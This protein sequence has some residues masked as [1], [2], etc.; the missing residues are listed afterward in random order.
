MFFLSVI[1][2]EW[3]NLSSTYFSYL[4]WIMVW[5]FALLLKSSLINKPTLTAWLLHTI[6]ALWDQSYS[7]HSC[8]NH[9]SLLLNHQLAKTYLSLYQQTVCL[10]LL[11]DNGSVTQINWSVWSCHIEPTGQIHTKCS[12]INVRFVYYVFIRAISYVVIWD[13]YH[14]LCLG[15]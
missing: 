4:V 9:R 8:S 12:R 14:T 2:T 13:K 3:L 11:L 15:Y 5:R 10:F 6:K 7:L 1:D